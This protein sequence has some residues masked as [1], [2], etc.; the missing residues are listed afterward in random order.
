MPVDPTSPSTPYLGAARSTVRS[1]SRAT[2][3][4]WRYQNNGFALSVPA[5]DSAK[6]GDLNAIWSD[7]NGTV[8]AAGTGL[9]RNVGNGWTGPVRHLRRFGERNVG[10]MGENDVWAV[11]NRAAVYHYDGNR[12]GPS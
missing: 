5:L 11:G 10:A 7:G 9:L 8:L 2:W 1:G 4:A 3:A 12:W 6:L